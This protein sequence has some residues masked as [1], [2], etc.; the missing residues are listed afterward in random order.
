MLVGDLSTLLNADDPGFRTL[1]EELHRHLLDRGDLRDV[2]AI[3]RALDHT[4]PDPD[5]V[6]PRTPRSG[7][8]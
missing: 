1:A 3:T 8:P 2:H 6:V 5:H 7:R 4:A